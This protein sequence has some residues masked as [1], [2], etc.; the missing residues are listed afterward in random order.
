MIILASKSPRRRELLAA[1][2]YKFEIRVSDADENIGE[3]IFPGDAVKILA[4]RK[5]EAVKP[6]AMADDIIIACDTLVDL[7]GHALGK[8]KD[9]DDA[10]S[11]LMS[12]SGKTHCVHSGI[13]VI[14]GRDMYSDVDTSFVTFVGFDEKTAREYVETGEPMDKAGAYAIQGLGA[15]FVDSMNG[16]LDT[17][18]GLPC[19]MLEHYLKKCGAVM[20]YTRKS[21]DFSDDR[22]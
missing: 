8:P 19:G 2:G 1:L 20:T 14:R 22:T 5:A 21:P 13:C 4:Q 15:R 16:N 7:D 12:L 3:E 17:V 18:I 10:V 11:M 9:K 6:T